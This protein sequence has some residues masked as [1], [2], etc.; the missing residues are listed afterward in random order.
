MA[1]S[2]FNWTEKIDIDH[3]D[4]S[5]LSLTSLLLSYYSESI[6]ALSVLLFIQQGLSPTLDKMPLVLFMNLAE[7]TFLERHQ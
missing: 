5:E 4:N 7:Y 3:T 6:E 2:L 1:L